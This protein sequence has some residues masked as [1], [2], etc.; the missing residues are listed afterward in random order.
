M[1]KNTI[2]TYIGLLLISTILFSCGGGGD[3]APPPNEPPTAVENLIFPSA[4]LLCIDNNITFDW[5][6]ATDPEGGNVRY[7]ILIARDRDL[8]QV[9]EERTVTESEVTITLERGVAFYWNIVSLD[10]ASAESAPTPT[11]AFFTMGDGVV[12]NVPFTAALVAPANDANVAP[13]T[14]NLSWDGADTDVGDVLTYDLYFGTDANPPLLE[15]GLTVENFD[16]MATTGTT[17][18]WRVD[19]IDD[20]GARSIGQVW[21]FTAN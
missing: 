17:Y 7:R 19:T 15:E 21:Q 18:F 11:Q 2:K 8:T 4:N 9:E 10:N 16:V 13:G 20:S 1:K 5:S 14:V 6:D 12:N 3:D